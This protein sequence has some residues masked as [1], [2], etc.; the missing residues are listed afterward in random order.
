MPPLAA[1]KILFSPTKDASK[2]NKIVNH[3]VP[4]SVSGKMQD[5]KMEEDTG[6]EINMAVE[7]FQFLAMRNES[8][9]WP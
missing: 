5:N 9:V 2:T 3:T 8:N 7:V 4:T 1:G 6:Y